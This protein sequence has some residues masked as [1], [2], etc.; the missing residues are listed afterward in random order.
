[1]LKKTP[2]MFTG[3]IVTLYLTHNYISEDFIDLNYLRQSEEASLFVSMAA[4]FVMFLSFVLFF[5]YRLILTHLH[6]TI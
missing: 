1:M 5:P 4:M 2:H 3:I 6:Q